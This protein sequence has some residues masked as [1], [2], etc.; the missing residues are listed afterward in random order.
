MTASRLPILTFFVML[1][2]AVRAH[3]ESLLLEDTFPVEPRQLPT[4]E[5]RPYP[6]PAKWAFT[7]WPGIV[8]P[9]SYGD[10]T[11][12]LENNAESQ[13]YLSRLV[14]RVRGTDIPESQRFD[15]FEVTAEGLLIRAGLLTP[16]QQRLY[17]VGGHRRFGSGMLLSRVSFTFGRVSIVAKLPSARGSWP[18]LWLLPENNDWPPEI[19]IVEAM[20]WAAHGRQ[21]HAGIIGL[22]S[23]GALPA[24]GWLN[25]PSRPA[26]GF[27][28]YGLVW[29]RDWVSFLYDGKVIR[30][31]PT[32][33]SLQSR[34]MYVIMNLA[35]GG[36]WP[37]NELGIAPI[38]GTS[39]ERLTAGATAIERDYP[40]EMIIRSI[41]I[42]QL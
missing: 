31:Q 35:V 17:Q 42:W 27:H 8:W 1:L 36:K 28:E 23:D 14:S 22:A 2:F 20:P 34:K 6:D 38:D 9:D 5:V 18:A 12:W 41:R 13:V 39:A 30:K 16:D 21:L 32:P 10:G 37:Y 40:A 29:D 4:G 19:D 25:L 11:N 33:R 24:P 15:P 7:F 3:A 26:D